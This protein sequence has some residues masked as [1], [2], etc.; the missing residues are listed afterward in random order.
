[1]F[2]SGINL[3][4]RPALQARSLFSTPALFNDYGRGGRQLV[5]SDGKVMIY[6][7]AGE[8]ITDSQSFH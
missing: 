5:Y 7:D 4:A 2:P 3:I 1:M 8:K 6:T